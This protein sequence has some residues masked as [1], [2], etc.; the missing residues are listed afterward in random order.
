M[1]KRDK[2]FSKQ[3]K[4]ERDYFEKFRTYNYGNSIVLM[5]PENPFYVISGRKEKY[6]QISDD[7]LTRNKLNYIKSFYLQTSKTFENILNHK[8]KYLKECKIERY[9]E[10]DPKLVRA[11]KKALPNLE[12]ILIPRTEKTVKI[13][14]TKGLQQENLF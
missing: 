8:I 1:F 7:W 12:T 4:F 10:D 6:R 13:I 14:Y 9:Y 5:R 3:N 11:I 2:P